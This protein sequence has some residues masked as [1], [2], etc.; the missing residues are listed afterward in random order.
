MGRHKWLAKTYSPTPLPQKAIEFYNRFPSSADESTN[1]VP[2]DR[3]WANSLELRLS[4]CLPGA[5][6]NPDQAGINIL[7]H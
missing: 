1:I 3:A 5:Y 7:T 4:V 2:E 6:R